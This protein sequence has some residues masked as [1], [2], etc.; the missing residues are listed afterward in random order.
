MI[1]T[2]RRL[3]IIM[4]PLFTLISG[5]LLRLDLDYRWLDWVFKICLSG[6]VGIW[7]NYFAIKMLFR[8]YRRTVFGRQG[9]IPA[10]RGELAG[11]IAQAV[12]RELLD[13]DSIL[14]YV[15]ENGLIDRTAESALEYV[16][17]W[18][19]DPDSRARATAA[20]AGYILDR[21]EEN[22][23]LLL[24]KSAEIVK[25]FLADRLPADT[26]WSYARSALESELE[27]PGTLEL[28][29]MVV[30]RIVQEN[31]PAIADM[32]NS[33]LEEWIDSRSFLV[34]NALK[35]GRDLLR[36][37]RGMIEEELL[38]RAGEPAF[39]DT[40]MDLLEE[41]ASSI[42]AMGEDPAVRERFS[43]FL[44]EQ[45][46]GLYEW[47]R[48]EG[49]PAARKKLLEFLRSGTFW[50]WLERQLDSAVTALKEYASGKVRSE[51]FRRTARDFLLEHAD[52]IDIEEIV[53]RK[54]DEFD[55]MQLEELINRVSGEN[56]CGIELFGGILGM[57]AGLVLIDQWFLLIIPAVMLVLWFI[58][59]VTGRA[60]G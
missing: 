16:H 9:L 34:K 58:E 38:K 28:L 52:K 24:A 5:I 3:A 18:V 56:L 12:A 1:R 39:V 37:D 26:V 40:V 6:T 43:R 45:K 7:T 42:A 19:D 23:D 20:V 25:G 14:S 4:L 51:E 59:R 48:T 29:T 35:L 30:T 57:V 53:R 36:V 27:K 54:V 47:A 50:D 32:V 46:T 31:A 2:G 33:M 41:N 22:A 44:E 10:R 15:E 8:P 55:L 49:I 21:G 60:V 11:A 17:R 13:T